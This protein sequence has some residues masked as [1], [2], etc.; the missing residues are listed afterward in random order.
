[1]LPINLRVG[2]KFI[3][4]SVF[5]AL[6]SLPHMFGR[7]REARKSLRGSISQQSRQGLDWLNFFL[8]D[9]QT[10]F[11]AFVAFYLADLGW[12][13]GQVGLALTVGTVAGV[14]SQIPGGALVDALRWK[15]GLAAIGIGMLCV[16]ALIFALMPSV[17]LV[18]VAEIL[19]GLTA[20]IVTPTI[21]A[22]SLGLVG[23]RAMSLRTGRNYRFNAAGN[24]L[25]AIMG[26]AGQYFAK[27]AI[28]FG[29]AAL[30]IPALVALSRIRAD[31]IDYAR[32]RNAGKGEQAKSY[33]RIF[34]LGK[35]RNLYIFA[36]CVFL[37]QFADASLLPV[38]GQN[39]AQ[40]ETEHA[41]LLM[42]G[43]IV[44]PQ[45]VVALLSPW[46]GYYSDKWGRKPLLL[47]GFG[48]EIIRALLF[49]FSAN[50][51]VLLTAQ[52]LGGI[53]AAA[54]TV[55]TI[56]VI[57][58]LTTGTGR[59]NLVRGFIG[60]LIAI[61]ASIS[62]TATGFLFEALGNWEGFLTLAAAS[63]IATALLCECPRQDRL[64]ISIDCC[65]SGV[66]MVAD[67]RSGPRERKCFRRV[68]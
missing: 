38:V 18:F 25:T 15:R 39:L 6:A 8:A 40:S 34:D 58:D 67:V 49:A 57:T 7:Y 60:T 44:V 29:A 1:M 5:A 3:G 54:V 51:S 52:L 28:F 17:A 53:S 33:H 46:V 21:A 24:A 36:A 45:I 4:K 62:T 27:S 63:A 50:V 26:L 42:A 11:G 48:L 68:W 64:N 59:F 32:A 31:E 35:N 10:A 19:H 12:S 61:A 65:I 9:V 16:S 66:R 56:L 2:K 14:I 47:V 30:C 55:L 22:I 41:S 43:L 20:G 23:R 37:F 13:K